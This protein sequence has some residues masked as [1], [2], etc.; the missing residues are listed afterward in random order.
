MPVDIYAN[1]D[2]N[3]MGDPIS[4]DVCPNGCEQLQEDKQGNILGVQAQLWSESARTQQQ[5]YEMINRLI[6][7]TERTWHKVG[8]I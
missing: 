8:K 7:L 6:A 4:Y 5:I 2:T 3:R 1:I